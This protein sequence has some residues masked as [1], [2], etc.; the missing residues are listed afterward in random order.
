METL[1]TIL[2]SGAVVNFFTVILGAGI[3]LIFKKGIPEKL[4][5]ALMTGMALCVLLIGI[6][7]ILND[8][9]KILVIIISVAAGAVI[10]ELIDL[11]KLVNRLG[12]KLEQQ[13]NKK[14]GNA[15]IAEGFISA[16]LLFCVG[17]MTIVGSLESGI[18]G[19]NMTIYSKAVID[20]V[21][22]ITFASTLGFGVMLSSASV[23]AIQGSITLLAV[24]IAPFLTTDIIT[25]MSTVGSLLIVALSFNMLGFTKIKVMNFVPAIFLPLLL[26]QFM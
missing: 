24:Y 7:G 15:K 1:K 22:A 25:Q 14:G 4:N 12:E 16:T 19:D 20:C 11:D 26:C 3:G 5:N 2:T 23:L 9:N 18:N 6:D 8:G 10:G 17:A 13:V 21:A